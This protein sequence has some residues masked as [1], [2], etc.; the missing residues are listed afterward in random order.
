MPQ[1]G[2]TD[3]PSFRVPEPSAPGT[4]PRLTA[5]MPPGNRAFVVEITECPRAAHVS[6]TVVS[7]VPASEGPVIR[8]WWSALAP[9]AAAR[10]CE[11]GSMSLPWPSPGLIDTRADEGCAVEYS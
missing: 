9:K 3:M 7:G 1:W 2:C 11:A 6:M 5:P 4:V 8:R 10:T